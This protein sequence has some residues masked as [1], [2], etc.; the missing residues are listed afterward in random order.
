MEISLALFY[1]IYLA[2]V[3]FF[4]LFSMLTIYPLV[5]HGYLNTGILLIMLIYIV[6]TIA[7]FSISWFFINQV[8]WHQ[9]IDLQAQF[10]NNLWRC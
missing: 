3:I 5:R 7:I 8:N 4:L 10:S 6:G 9:F 1:Y 2:F